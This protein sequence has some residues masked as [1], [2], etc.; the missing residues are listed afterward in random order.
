MVAAY[1][2]GIGG[3]PSQDIQTKTEEM[4]NTSY[5]KMLTFR[6]D[7]GCFGYWSGDGGGDVHNT[8]LGLMVLADIAQVMYVDPDVLKGSAQCLL[9]S[10]GD[11]GNLAYR[12]IAVWA[13]CLCANTGNIEPPL[14]ELE[15]LRTQGTQGTPYERALVGNALAEFDADDPGVKEIVDGLV[16]GAVVQGDEAWWDNTGGTLYGSYG[17]YEDM[18]ATGLVLRLLLV[19]G[20]E[21]P[22]AE[23]ALA[24][25]V[26]QKESWGGWGSTEATVAALRALAAAPISALGTVLVNCHG[27]ELEVMEINKD[28]G[29]LLHMVDLDSCMTEAEN[30]WSFTFDGLGTLHY[31]FEGEYYTEFEAEEPPQEEFTLTVVYDEGDGQVGLPVVASVDAANLAGDDHGMTIIGVTVPLGMSV[32]GSNLDELKEA[33]VLQEWELRDGQVVV[34]LQDFPAGSEVQFDVEM[35][36]GYPVQT[37]IAPSVIYSYYTPTVRSATPPVQIAID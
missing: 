5:Q 14:A 1:Y 17:S 34:Y 7:S 3:Y 28:N 33:G 9:D 23:K 10:L 29:D 18:V 32:V 22:L 19:A 35:T 37:S 13:L 21:G 31:Q 20:Q 25:L 11:G 4:L 27:E 12:A 36:P 30:P 15:Y 8:A 2:N 16:E 26:S 6:S 24:W